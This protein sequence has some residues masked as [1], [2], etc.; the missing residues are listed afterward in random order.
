MVDMVQIEQALLNLLRNSLDAIRDAG[1]GTIAIEAA[2]KD[3]DFV[4]VTVRD[5]GP[6]FPPDRAPTRSCRCLRPRR[7]GWASD[8][9]CA[10]RS[11]KLMAAASGSTPTRPAPP[12]I[13]PCL[14]P[15][16]ALS[17]YTKPIHIALVDD[18]TAVRDS[19]HLY[20][21]CH[22]VTASRRDAHTMP[23]RIPA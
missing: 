13:S 17:R 5:S 19:L 6:G 1:Q 18:C 9:R 23:Q 8:S 2:L 22:Q 16:S 11:S 10:G 14:S 12:C 7:K 4:V 21:A 15:P 3:A 20:F